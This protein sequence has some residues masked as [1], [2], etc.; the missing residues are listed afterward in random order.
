[1][2]DTSPARARLAQPLLD[3]LE[4]VIQT[5]PDSWSA[6]CPA[7]DDR[8]PSL[9][10]READGRVLFHCF[11]GCDPDDILRSVGLK[12]SDLYPDRW[13]AAREAAFAT[14]GR[15]RSKPVQRVLVCGI[16]IEIE[17]RILELVAD[18]VRSGRELSIED[19]ARAEVARQR[20]AAANAEGA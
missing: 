10:V 5:K 9:S 19:R 20:V 3:R 18:G 17:R 1:M 12:W 2:H 14:A 7:H 13:D 6:R 15:K 8:S 4:G 11:A 16:D